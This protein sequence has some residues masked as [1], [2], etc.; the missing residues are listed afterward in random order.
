[1][2]EDLKEKINVNWEQAQKGNIDAFDNLYSV[3]LIHHAP[4][5]PD[6]KGLKGFKKMYEHVRAAFSDLQLTVHHRVAE[7]D[8]V[9]CHV[10][11]RGTH[12]G[13]SRIVPVPRTGKIIEWSGC[14]MYRFAGDK[15][16]E[17]WWY[18]DHL[19]FFQQLGAIPKL[20]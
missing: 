14:S 5:F 2:R 19:G 10:T 15:C 7:G 12:T 18:T 16:V 4:P 17:Q 9:V 6:T 11:F 8:V 3:D 1:M 13:K 20:W